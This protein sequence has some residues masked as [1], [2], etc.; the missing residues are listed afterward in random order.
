MTKDKSST[1]FPTT[2]ENYHNENAR[3]EGISLRDYLAAKVIQGIFANDALLSRYGKAG[4]EN[5][6]S[7]DVLA[8]TAAYSFADAALAVRSE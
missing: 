5:H 4:K 1:V 2:E 7:P 8:A 3:S 6:V